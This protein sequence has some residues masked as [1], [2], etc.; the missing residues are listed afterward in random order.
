MYLRNIQIKNKQIII[1]RANLLELE[2]SIIDEEL[3]KSTK[4]SINSH[5]LTKIANSANSAI[6]NKV[7]KLMVN[8]NK[9]RDNST[10]LE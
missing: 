5:T 7:A 1:R 6:L 4:Q 9:K 2:P 10:I 3:D 8:Y